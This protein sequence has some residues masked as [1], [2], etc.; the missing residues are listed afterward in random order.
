LSLS[1]AIIISYNVLGL[2]F[3]KNGSASSTA[4][5][6]DKES[7]YLVNDVTHMA[8]HHLGVDTVIQKGRGTREGGN[9]RGRKGRVKK[10]RED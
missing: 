10:G 3:F 9:N 1:D 7:H 5:S 2:F 6:R 8:R 4:V